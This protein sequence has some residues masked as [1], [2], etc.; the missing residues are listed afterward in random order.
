[1]SRSA[2]AA[3]RERRCSPR[4]YGG[5]RR[6]RATIVA[7]SSGLTEPRSWSPPM[8]LRLLVLPCFVASCAAVPA[9]SEEATSTST[10]AIVK[11]TDSDSAQD[12]TVLVM[13]YDALKEGGGAA[14]GCTGSLLTPRLVLTARH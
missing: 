11:G 9:G 4:L 6:G 1:M 14:S 10:S 12:A 3:A 8:K 2:R 7:P 13:H 5:G